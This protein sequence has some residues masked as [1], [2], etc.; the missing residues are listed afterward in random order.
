M[1]TLQRY[2]VLIVFAILFVVGLL[3]RYLMGESSML[4]G[5]WSSIDVSF[6]VV[7]GILA[8]I[9]Y[10]NI[11]RAEDQIRLVFNIENKKEVDTGLCL[12]RK[13]C[14]RSEVIGVISMMKYTN[15]HL[16]YDVD[17][18][19][20]L[21]EEINQVQTGTKGKL[22]IPINEDEFSQFDVKNYRE[23]K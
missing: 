8:Y 21:L 9:A 10:R 17:N 3:I 11:V 2:G 22:F 1:Q 16:K 23:T 6:A 20:D 12:L 4:W 15:E 14:T 19:H 18:L 5:I 13:N 7:L